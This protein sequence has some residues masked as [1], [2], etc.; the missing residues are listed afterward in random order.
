MANKVTTLIRN[1]NLPGIGWRRGTLIQSKNG[2]IKPDAMLY[3]GIEYSAPQGT[4]QIRYYRGAKVVYVTVGNDLNAALAMLERLNA[5]RQ[6]EAAE[7]T[8]GIAPA[9]PMPKKVMTIEEL[10][11]AF[12]KKRTAG[13]SNA[14]AALYMATLFSFCKFFASA[15]KTL[16][17]QITGDD[18]YGTYL[19][20]KK[21]GRKQCT[22][23]NRYS[24]L[25]GF[26]HFMKIL[27]RKK[28]RGFYADEN[29]HVAC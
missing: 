13:V 20:W 11:V 25:R 10:K 12:L 29:Y 3:N 28:H 6:K 17:E 23:A 4:Y 5:T 24:T 15:G 1:A 27:I 14:N 22:C 19:R 9:I 8:L 7:I 2:R 21:E 26:L 16:P 18:V